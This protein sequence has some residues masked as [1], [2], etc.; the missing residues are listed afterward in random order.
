MLLLIFYIPKKEKKFPKKE[1]NLISIFGTEYAQYKVQPCVLNWG[2]PKRWG[3]F[4]C[5]RFRAG[6]VPC[7]PFLIITLFLDR[8]EQFKYHLIFELDSFSQ[9]DRPDP[10]TPFKNVLFFMFFSCNSF[11]EW[12]DQ[13]DSIGKNNPLYK[14]FRMIYELFETVQK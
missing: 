10:I 1:K 3:T 2:V 9:L 5:L 13:I 6:P 11:I 12:S 4:P 14:S 8:F 7:Q